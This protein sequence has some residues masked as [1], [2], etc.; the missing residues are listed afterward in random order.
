M[1]KTTSQLWKIL[2]NSKDIDR[3]IVE[4]EGEM[5]DITL[6]EYLNTL[7][8]QYDISKTEAIKKSNI[9]QSYGYHLFAGTKTNPSRNHILQLAFGMGLG[10]EDTQRLL[11]TAGL[12]ELSPRK[13]FDNIIIY[14][15]VNKIQIEECY[16]ILERNGCEFIYKV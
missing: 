9:Q 1:K 8:K 2:K 12:S 14:C 13:K 15:I 6:A 11:R 4:N 10:L 7:L 3:Y 5:M 16:T